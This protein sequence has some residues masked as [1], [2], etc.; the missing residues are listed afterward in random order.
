MP[1]S[2][3][4]ISG[5]Q[6][7]IGSL[8]SLS[9]SK[10]L[11]SS[12][13]SALT[14]AL[15]DPVGAV[16]AKTLSS[17]NSL[18]YNVSEKIDLLK[19]N[20]IKSADNTGKVKLVNNVIIITVEPEDINKGKQYQER[21]QKDIDR[22]NKTVNQIKT[23]VSTLHVITQTV[24]VLKT[25]MAVQEALLTLGNP[26]ATATISLL[27]KALKIFSYKD[28]LGEYAK[29]LSNQVSAQESLL[30]DIVAKFS[31]LSVQFVINTNNNNGIIKTPIQAAAD[32]RDSL[33]STSQSQDFTS[34]SGRM[35]TLTIETYGTRELIG[36]AKDKFSQLLVSETSPSFI[37]TPDQ[38]LQE[39]KTILNQ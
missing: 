34:D 27:K 31:S 10:D 3:A 15:G 26:V 2:S 13:S 24:S 6:S 19:E 8:S 35:Y 38:L 12:A 20:I 17:I 28:A 25:A 7:S 39:L 29:I 36:R 9:V 30:S 23:L 33:L 32:I 5:I 21:I 4:D 11:A 18:S 16:L 14:S 1:I 37:S 22:L